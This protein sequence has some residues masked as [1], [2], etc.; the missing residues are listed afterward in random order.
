MRSI[1]LLR[2]MVSI[3]PLSSISNTRDSWEP[4]SESTS[5]PVEQV[6]QVIVKQA[7]RALL[8]GTADVSTQSE[9]SE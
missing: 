6:V 3:L 4:R 9:H 5:N 1:L 7:V 8:H 2:T